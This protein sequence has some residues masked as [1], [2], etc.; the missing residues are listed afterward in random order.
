MVS[1]LDVESVDGLKKM[2][3]EKAHSERAISEIL[4]WY[5]HEVSNRKA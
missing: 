1:C 2:L 5:K 3:T 4:K